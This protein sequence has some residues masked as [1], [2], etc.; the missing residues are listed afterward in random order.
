M[1]RTLVT[2]ELRETAWI[3]ALALVAYLAVVSSLVDM[4]LFSF[5]YGKESGIPFVSENF[6][7]P[8]QVITAALA[9]AV[10][11]RQSAWEMVRGTAVFLFHRP[12][13]R[14][15]VILTKVFTGLAIYFLCSL[16]PIL[17]YAWWAA[18]PGNYPA[19]FEW[20]M[21]ATVFQNWLVFSVFYLGAFAS[22]MRAAR[23]FGSRLFP[24]AASAALIAPLMFCP[25]WWLNLLI[26]TCV[27]YPLLI[28]DILWE[29][30]QRDY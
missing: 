7:L 12:V 3:A 8:F 22:G 2:K 26:V 1:I 10:G 16:V 29:A 28:A 24:L 4:K 11:F 13:A 19:P 14:S 17:I 15:T 5:A 23:W 25:W 30:S 27:I 6:L 20:S 18:T 9:I 21:T